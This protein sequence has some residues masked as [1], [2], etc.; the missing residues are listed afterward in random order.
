M[1]RRPADASWAE[2]IRWGLVGAM[3]YALTYLLISFTAEQLSINPAAKSDEP[4]FIDSFIDTYGNDDDEDDEDE[5]WW[6]NLGAKLFAITLI[7]GGVLILLLFFAAKS[8]LVI[9][10]FASL[11][12][13]TSSIEVF[14]VI[15]LTTALQFAQVHYIATPWAKKRGVEL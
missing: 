9:V 15:V 6:S 2:S 4:D 13:G 8:I 5:H 11:V 7:A 1:L 10:V 3:S 12:K 14:F